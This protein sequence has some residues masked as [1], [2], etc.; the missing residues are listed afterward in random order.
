MSSLRQKVGTAV[1]LAGVAALVPSVWQ[2]ATHITDETYRAPE[3]RHGEGHVQYHMA[4]EVLICTGSMGVLVMGALAGQNRSRAVWRGMAASAAG[5]GAALWSGG[6]TTGVWA[7]N[8]KALLIHL[9]S[10]TGL[11]VGV[12]LLR[13]KAGNR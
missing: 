1:T 4:R 8:R 3:A 9:A 13:P 7:P 12:A 2:T 5:I 6:P 11:G 10:T